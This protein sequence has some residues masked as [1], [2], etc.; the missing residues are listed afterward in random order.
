MP[1]ANTLK[2]IAAERKYDRA[3]AAQTRI[4][5][6]RVGLAFADMLRADAEADAERAWRK[7]TRGRA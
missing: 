1:K 2:Q 7:R 5:D 6:E 3:C 4:P